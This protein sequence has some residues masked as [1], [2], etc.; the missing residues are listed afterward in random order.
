MTPRK[1]V[2]WCKRLQWRK[3]VTRETASGNAAVNPEDA[4][5]PNSEKRADGQHVDHWVLS[6]EERA[7][8]FVRPVRLSYVHVGPP[9]PKFELRELTDEEKE[10][11]PGYGKYEQ[12]PEGYRGSAIGRFWTKEQLD[13]IGKGCGTKTSMPRAIAETYA[14]QPGYYGSTFC[15][16][17]GKYLPVGRDGEFVWDGT[18]ERVGT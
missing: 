11:Y 3:P 6:E 14:A 13:A 1:A 5:V 17:C 15:C 7:K 12:Y 18:T 10:R 2:Y 4:P 9:G 16:G 8:G